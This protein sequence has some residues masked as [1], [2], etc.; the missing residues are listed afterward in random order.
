[1]NWQATTADG[2]HEA[3]KAWRCCKSQIPRLAAICIALCVFQVFSMFPKPA[4][5]SKVSLVIYLISGL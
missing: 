1:M 4:D 3:K 2:I 5:R